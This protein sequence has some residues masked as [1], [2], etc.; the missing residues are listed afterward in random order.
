MPTFFK[1]NNSFIAT[2]LSHVGFIWILFGISRYPRNIGLCRMVN[3]LQTSHPYKW[4]V[5]C[6][7][8]VFQ[9][10]GIHFLPWSKIQ[11]LNEF[12][13]F[14]FSLNS[15]LRNA[16]C[17]ALPSHVC[18]YKTWWKYWKVSMRNPIETDFDVSLVSWFLTLKPDW[19]KYKLSNMFVIIFFYYKIRTNNWLV[20]ILVKTFYRLIVFKRKSLLFTILLN[21]SIF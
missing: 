5:P 8:R 14:K 18:L 7:M 13:F 1:H 17:S 9:H 15:E 3:L 2:V 16:H 20:L 4:R 11:I 21:D 6:K 10:H 19:P 12:S